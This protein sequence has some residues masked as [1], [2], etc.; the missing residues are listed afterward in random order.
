[1][2]KMCERG[3]VRPRDTVDDMLVSTSF[4]LWLRRTHETGRSRS[5]SPIHD[6]PPAKKMNNSLRRTGLS[7]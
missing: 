6:L 1:M 5:R 2:T 3:D 4:S 7:N